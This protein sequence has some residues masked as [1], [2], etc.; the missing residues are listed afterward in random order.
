MDVPMIF[1]KFF[2]YIYII[3]Y[4]IGDII[5]NSLNILMRSF[6]K[7]FDIFKSSAT[8]YGNL[9]LTSDSFQQKFILIFTII[10]SLALA[11]TITLLAV[12]NN[13]EQFIKYL[14][15]IIIGLFSI[16]SLFVLAY[17][18]YLQSVAN[19]SMPENSLRNTGLFIF[20]IVMM[21]SFILIYIYV[22]PLVKMANEISM[23][24]MLI[25]S[26]L[27]GVLLLL[28]F[29]RYLFNKYSGLLVALI[30][31]VLIL[32]YEN[33]FGVFSKYTAPS[34]FAI[35][36]VA[37]ALILLMLVYQNNQIT[38]KNP[39]YNVLN[40]TIVGL[41][42]LLFTAA[43][44][45]AGFTMKTSVS[46]SSLVPSKYMFFA[47]ILV[48]FAIIYKIILRTGV[49]N[50]NPTFKF[51]VNL[52][53]YIPCILVDIIDYISQIFFE[54][55]NTTNK[56]MT[57]LL[58][59]ELLL[60]FFYFLFPVLKYKYYQYL[61]I[62]GN[63]DARLLIN[64]PKPLYDK[65]IVGT[66]QE[67]NC[68]NQKDRTTTSDDGTIT[69]VTINS[70]DTATTTTTTPDG[71]TTTFTGQPLCKFEYNYA[72]SLWFNIDSAAPSNDFISIFNYGEQPNIKYQ[73]STNTLIITMQQNS[74][75][76]TMSEL[77][78]KMK[79]ENYNKLQISQK[80]KEMG[81]ELDA[82]NNLIVYKN[83]ELQL[84]KW[85]N[86]VINYT[87]GTLDIFLNSNLVRSSINIAPF[88]DYDNLVVGR[89]NGLNGGICSLIYYK[90]SLPIIE[91]HN[92][93]N[94][95][96]DSNPPIFPDDSKIFNIKLT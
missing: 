30:F 26:I 1:Y 86:L 69:T 63:N 22:N 38:D 87:G 10:V 82:S 78:K 43:I 44:I 65:Y 23:H 48:A 34:I 7:A 94:T 36:A 52:I 31:L 80:L 66:Y 46:S 88:M 27:L 91:I 20:A 45:Y 3:I 21:I 17:N 40:R 62:D 73:G 50:D 84:Q 29:N 74:D 32:T 11:I 28:S 75:N 47:I 67:I 13:T 2:G 4:S 57:I 25:A 24:T 93:Y 37:S 19:L 58:L 9:V 76:S 61:F 56:S 77:I 12:Y 42:A 41:V 6:G 53:F 71:V 96:K 68:P 60:L 18:I 35:I 70:D 49:L 16:M 79:E 92:I 33:P 89:T 39:T 85:N 64:H 83:T 51:I 5:S 90:R 14:G 8:P 55:Y 59:I 95:F 15:F 54:T 72:I 81:I